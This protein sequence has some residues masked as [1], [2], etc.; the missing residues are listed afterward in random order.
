[1]KWFTL[2]ALFVVTQAQATYFC[3]SELRDATN[4]FSR[5]LIDFDLS[6]KAFIKSLDL[7]NQMKY[8]DAKKQ[9]VIA[10]TKNDVALVGMDAAENHLEQIINLCPDPERTLASDRQQNVNQ[11]QIEAKFHQQQVEELNI[12]LD[13]VLNGVDKTNYCY[14]YTRCMNGAIVS[15]YSYGPACSWQ[16]TPYGVVC[17]GYDQWGNWGQ[18]W[19]RCF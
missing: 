6:K 17:N 14:G 1:M 8:A 3:V 11:K 19:G 16:S 15:C 18:F 12:L 10:K 13:R 7:V 4:K 2:V 9:A 5:S